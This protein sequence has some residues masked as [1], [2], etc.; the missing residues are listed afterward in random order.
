MDLDPA[1]SHRAILARDARY[2]GL[3]F[4]CVRTTGIYCRPIRPARP[5]PAAMLREESRDALAA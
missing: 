4:T 2:D 5:P 3:F 1:Q